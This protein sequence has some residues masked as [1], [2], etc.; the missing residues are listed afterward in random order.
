MNKQAYSK[1]Y[2]EYKQLHREAMNDAIK[3]FEQANPQ[4]FAELQA[5]AHTEVN[6]SPKPRT[7]TRYPTRL[8]PHFDVDEFI[9]RYHTQSFYI[10]TVD[11][12][13]DK[14]TYFE[15]LDGETPEEVLTRR[16]PKFAERREEV[17]EV[18]KCGCP[19]CLG[20]N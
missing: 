11:G 1:Q 13:G 3:R 10:Y 2:N 12:W 17:T 7:V 9:R 8:P 5:Q 15:S 18:V 16:H 20:L 19:L 6:E 14:H 4:R